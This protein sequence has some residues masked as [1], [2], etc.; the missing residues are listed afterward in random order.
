MLQE[1]M[2]CAE[3]AVSS[4][5]PCTG[6]V[7]SVSSVVPLCSTLSR[8]GRTSLWR[9]SAFIIT[10]ENNKVVT[11]SSKGPRE[12][13][14]VQSWNHG[15]KIMKIIMTGVKIVYFCYRHRNNKLLNH[16]LQ[17]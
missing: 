10:E 15:N 3:A 8:K 11:T 5:S 12:G 16:G 17:K 4:C 13:G 1:A 9:C 6:Y 2:N 14:A 7:D